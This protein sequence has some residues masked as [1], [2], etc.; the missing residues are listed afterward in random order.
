MGHHIVF[1]F[2]RFCQPTLSPSN[3]WQRCD[4]LASRR[5]RVELGEE[6]VCRMPEEVTPVGR[7]HPPAG[8]AW[9]D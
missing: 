6:R 5:G 3:N 8:G 4:R 7:K 1:T 9:M 2:Y